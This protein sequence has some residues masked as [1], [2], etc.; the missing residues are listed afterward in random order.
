MKGAS[1]E[2]QLSMYDRILIATDGSEEAE[3]AAER[4]LDLAVL[5]DAVVDVL[6]VVERF[7][8]DLT[9]SER[10][11]EQLTDR[12]EAA[13][14]QVEERA[15][16][17]GLDVATE[18][19]EGSPAT[20]IDE[21]AT[22]RGAGLIVLGRQ[23]ATG[24]RERLLGSVTE[25][26]VNESDVPTLVVPAEADAAPLGEVTYEDVLLPT[27]GSEGAAAAIPHGVAVAGDAG[28]TLHVL[29]VVDLQEAGGLFDA[30]GLETEFVERLESQGRDAVDAV[31]AAA[32]RQAPR[33]S[34]R[35]AVVRTTS[36]RGVAAGIREYL[37][38]H[39]AD[40]VVMGSHG[41]SKLGRQ[42]V[43]SVASRV[44]RI[45]DAPVLVVPRSS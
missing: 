40:L 28:G 23:G 41:R 20:R 2:L 8:V 7:A 12:G 42:L 45:V 9:R 18:L 4:G 36:H 25:Q 22:E 32:E 39:D 29:N 31:A 44:L 30:G 15:A 6:Y 3:N 43:G 11:E 1:A 38:E 14:R 5:F 27:D 17:R 35:T 10:E 33:L 34:V 13:L 21:Y 24:V 26:V 19:T 16:D 37:E